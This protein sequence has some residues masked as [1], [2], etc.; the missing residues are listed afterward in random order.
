MIQNSINLI[1]HESHGNFNMDNIIFVKYESELIKTIACDK[2][3]SCL[4]QTTSSVP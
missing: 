4:S 3:E 2:P 1:I